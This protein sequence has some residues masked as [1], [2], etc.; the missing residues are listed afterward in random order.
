MSTQFSS[1]GQNLVTWGDFQSA[2]TFLLLIVPL[3]KALCGSL[4]LR[5]ILLKGTTCYGACH[6]PSQWAQDR[7]PFS[8]GWKRLGQVTL[9]KKMRNFSLYSLLPFSQKKWVGPS[10]GILRAIQVLSVPFLLSRSHVS[11][12]A[13]VCQTSLQLRRR[14]GLGWTSVAG[15]GEL[16]SVLSLL[17]LCWGGHL[18]AVVA[19]YHP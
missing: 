10:L 8:K 18:P 2:R 17:G 11:L 4:E 14:G 3:K 1:D 19:R 13:W 15:H 12:L 5:N 7:W 6:R 16:P 9:C